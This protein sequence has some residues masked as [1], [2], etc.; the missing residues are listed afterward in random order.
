MVTY[1][2]F[3]YFPTDN[4]KMSL[5]YRILTSVSVV[6]EGR[7]SINILIRYQCGYYKSLHTIYNIFVLGTSRKKNSGEIKRSLIQGMRFEDA[8]FSLAHMVLVTT[9]LLFHRS[10]LFSLFKYQ[11]LTD[12]KFRIFSCFLNI[13]KTSLNAIVLYE[14]LFLNLLNNT[15]ALKNKYQLIIFFK[16]TII[17]DD[18][19]QVNDFKKTITIEAKAA[20]CSSSYCESVASDFCKAT[21]ST[22]D[23]C[24]DINSIQT[25][26]SYLL[27]ILNLN[28]A[29][30]IKSYYE[31]IL[32][33]TIY[34]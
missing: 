3:S 30:I 2:L 29:P 5:N 6:F 17:S 34:L 28:N 18:V 7:K 4:F 12:K 16:F 27:N 32:K 20:L 8:Q 25:T 14:F 9:F 15:I 1:W 22:I 31:Q 33:I 13:I 23:P 19:S 24:K 10:S 26:F 21:S 11:Y